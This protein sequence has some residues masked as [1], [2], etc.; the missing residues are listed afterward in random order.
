MTAQPAYPFGVDHYPRFLDETLPVRRDLTPADLAAFPRDPFWDYELHDGSL[1][2]SSPDRALTRRDLGDFP[3]HESWMFELFE[4]VLVATRNAPRERHQ[5]CAL[6]LAI[7]LRQACPPELKTMVGP[8]E[9]SPEETTSVQP[10]V[11]V[12]RRPMG[13]DFLERPPLL[14][15]EV[16]SPSSQWRDKVRKR[17]AYEKIGVPQYWIVD[18]AGPSVLVLEL[19]DGSYQERGTTSAGE[20]FV[21]ETPVPVRFNPADL[22]D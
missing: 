19:V 4:G 5:D 17:A 21:S 15:V 7:L 18:P 13:P 22:I 16:L 2:V 12:G 3:E 6:S 14:A 8:Y 11:M 1:V 9:F 10:D 20:V